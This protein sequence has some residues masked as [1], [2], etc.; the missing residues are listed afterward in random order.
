MLDGCRDDAAGTPRGAQGKRHT[1]EGPI[2]ALAAAARKEN[3]L[4]RCPRREAVCRR[5]FSTAARASRPKE[6]W[7]DG[8]PY[9]PAS[10]S[11]TH[12]V[13]RGSGGVVAA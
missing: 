4:R 13:T 10:A 9:R 6:Y 5:A 7:L 11:A 12:D 2:I 3:L 1:L 8:L